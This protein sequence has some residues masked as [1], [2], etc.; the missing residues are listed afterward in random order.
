MNSQREKISAEPGFKPGAAGWA[1]RVLPLCHT[2]SPH[3]LLDVLLDVLLGGARVADHLL[4]E[5]SRGF[6]NDAKSALHS[7]LQ[8]SESL[9]HIL[10][11][12]LTGRTLQ[13]KQ[14]KILGFFFVGTAVAEW[15]K[16]L[17]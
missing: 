8:T 1:A 7:F 12:L 13:E 5:L 4:R 15:P 6:C 17:H 11:S 16:A 9:E 3:L 14:T 10:S 2:A